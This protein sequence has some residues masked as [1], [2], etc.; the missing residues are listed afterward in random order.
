[1]SET[2][3]RIKNLTEETAL[4]NDD[5]FAIDNTSDGLRKIAPEKMVDKTLTVNN[6]PANAKTVGDNL[7]N[8]YSSSE[9]YIAGEHVL[10]NGQIYK[11]IE[12]IATAE[13]WTAAHWKAV[14]IVEDIGVLNSAANEFKKGDAYLDLLTEKWVIGNLNSNGVFNPA[15]KSR[16][17]TYG[18]IK[19]DTEIVIVLAQA[20]RL[21]LCTY[22]SDYSLLERT[23]RGLSDSLIL[24]PENTIFRITAYI[25]DES[26]LEDPM[27]IGKLFSVKNKCLSSKE[28]TIHPK[29]WWWERLT[30]EWV[31]GALDMR[32]RMIYGM[33][34]YLYRVVT[35]NFLKC[36]S[37]LVIRII[38][39]HF[40]KIYVCLYN[41]DKSFISRT[42]YTVPVTIPANTFFRVMAEGS[43]TSITEDPQKA[44]V[45][46]V[47][48]NVQ[49]SILMGYTNDSVRLLHEGKILLRSSVV[50]GGLYT[51]GTVRNQNNRVTFI[52]YM[53]Y[54]SGIDLK[55]SNN[56]L[57][58]IVCTYNSDHTFDER[59]VYARPVNTISI[60]AN[61]IF[62][63]TIYDP[64]YD[65]NS[66]YEVTDPFELAEQIY[67]P[68][69]QQ[70]P[71]NTDTI[72]VV[73][74]FESFAVIGDSLS[75]GYVSSGT[76]SSYG[77]NMAREANRNWPSY[78]GLRLDRPFTNL[79]RGSSSARDWRYGNS[80]LDVDIN[81]ADIDTYCYMIALGV[82]D[83]RNGLS[84]GTSA[85][86][87]TDKSNNTDSFYGNYDFIIRQLLEYKSL[88]I[89]QGKIFVFTIP[90]N[91]SGAESYNAAIRYVA[92]LYSDVH[93]IDLYNL[94]YREFTSEPLTG[95]WIGGHSRPLGYAIV[96]DY[97]RKAIDNYMLENYES[98][99]YDPWQP[100]T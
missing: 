97:I 70:T 11:C 15:Y 89:S 100:L 57:N 77:S 32:G 69:D 19:T 41:D 23:T 47:C 5:Y 91:V 12:N 4:S 96:G 21:I 30:A 42:D 34:E 2:I 98:F 24:I 16:A 18:F 92:S 78:L 27:D 58:V 49:N 99:S 26:V 63:V 7:A 43:D 39:T 84:V 56:R 76:G 73:S 48:N 38:D 9:T 87:K 88:R 8:E 95:L 90:G 10:Y 65:S 66:D 53:K 86:I 6:I 72:D 44:E 35:R 64:D 75:C 45:G 31:N 46:V 3:V 94:Y 62:R 40:S 51:D 93:C 28:E 80:G 25:D 50:V 68:V 71:T 13:E 85:D 22:D 54:D 82:N 36:S 1:M 37:D 33:P 52:D 20:V 59:T 14:N 61:T 29:K 79:A 83:L 67:I 74:I 81:T 17:T 55:V 60:S